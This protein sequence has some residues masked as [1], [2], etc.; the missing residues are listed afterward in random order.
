MGRWSAQQIVERGRIW[1]YMGR[2]ALINSLLDAGVP[3]LATYLGVAGIDEQLFMLEGTSYEVRT[4]FCLKWHLMILFHPFYDNLAKFVDAVF[5]Y[6]TILLYLGYRLSGC[7]EIVFG[8]TEF[9]I[10]SFHE[11]L[12]GY[13]AL[14]MDTASL[15][16]RCYCCWKCF[17]WKGS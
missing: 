9:K 12:L 3:K 11:V 7:N 1:A 15:F 16:F 2:Q 13:L 4:E 5:S 17:G 8:Y 10:S 6:E 14:R